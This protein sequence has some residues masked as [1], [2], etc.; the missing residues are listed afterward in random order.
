MNRVVNFG[1]RLN[2]YEAGIIDSHL[3]D[4]G[5]DDTIVVNT[6]AVTAEAERQA[7]QA[8]RRLRRDHP[9]ATIV[10][11]GCAAEIDR[12]AWDTMPE[13]DRVVANS[14]KTRRD[15]WS[16]LR[17]AGVRG[18]DRV[19]ALPAGRTRAFVEI[20]NGCDHHCT[21]CIIPRGRGA[22]RSRPAGDVIDDIQ[23]I[24]AA[25]CLEVVL[26]GVDITAW[27]NDLP[28]RPRLGD[29]VNRILKTVP[30]L[31]RLR[32][33]SLDIA[34]VD[35]A[36]L[37]ILAMEER[38]MPHLHLSLQAGDAMILKRMRRRHTPH[39][40]VRFCETVRRL[41]PGVV[42][43]ADLIAG[44]PTETDEMFDNTLAHVTDCGLTWLHVFPYSERPGTPAAKMPAVKR[45]LRKQ[46][47]AR[48]R[49]RGAMAAAAFLDSCVGTT[50]TVLVETPGR[51]RS[52]HFAP[53]GTPPDLAA[54]S[55][56][57]LEITG[58]DGTRLL[59]GSPL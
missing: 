43:G 25:G 37:R 13:I 44:F 28:G 7:R 1:C 40:A 36:L 53:V 15:T 59:A 55:L 29:L 50:A 18:P 3:K 20:Q 42:F 17:S 6:C 14:K 12:E 39:Q 35:D 32:L 45:H 41:R 16:T 48:L 5:I 33:T 49:D 56:R 2:A 54:G 52:E 19:S 10:A 22:S 11:T 46:R 8:V 4:E 38:L 23:D 30:P 51:G 57:T 31:P 21:F 24:V 9:G 27:G 58:T 34:E 47:A 26:T